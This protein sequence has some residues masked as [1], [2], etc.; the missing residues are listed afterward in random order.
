MMNMRYTLY[1]FSCFD[2]LLFFIKAGF[3]SDLYVNFSLSIL[4]CFLL[5]YLHLLL[6]LIE[7][8]TLEKC[9]ETHLLTERVQLYLSTAIFGW[10]SGYVKRV[11]G[12]SI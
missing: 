1:M 2:F 11:G 5:E 4:P 3:I 7:K 8:P 6:T 10:F 9:T 12:L